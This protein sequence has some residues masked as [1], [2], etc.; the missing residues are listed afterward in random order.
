MKKIV[1]AT[2]IIFAVIIATI[3]YMIG[4][5][6]A[7]ENGTDAAVKIG[8]LLNGTADDESWGQALVNGLDKTSEELK[9]D[10]TYVENVPFDEECMDC[11]EELIDDGCKIIICNSVGYGE[12]EMEVARRHED[13]YFFHA[14][15]TEYSDNFISYFGRIYQMR[16]LSGIVAGLQTQTG[17]IGYI[18]AT[19]I[20]EVNR[21]I[22]A[23]TLG[24]RKV[25]PDASV[26]VKFCDTWT[27]DEATQEQTNQLLT[28]HPDIDVLAM[29]TDSLKVLD[30]AEEKG[31]WSIGYNIDNSEKYPETYLTAPVWQ[32][33][34]FF[35]KHIG[36]CLQGTFEGQNYWLGADSGVIALAPLTGNVRA[37]TEQVVEQELEKLQS[38]TFD[39]FYGPVRDNHG[40]LRISE[41]ESMPDDVMLNQF[42]WYV[43][44]VVTDE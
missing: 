33:E 20:S 31:I 3:L 9:L 35:I 26:Y 30:V 14:T 21:G 16:Y 2:V 37:G 7:R 40:E 22:N 44:G 4:N 19:A 5:M 29:H 42:D 18:A 43:E 41:G 11:M 15:G 23:F 28:E 39:V 17:S 10:I 13:I 32:W 1:I 12:Y 25:N 24:V 6:A 36:E 8:V 27:D 34:N 38:G